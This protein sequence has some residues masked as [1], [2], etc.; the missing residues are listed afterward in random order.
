MLDFVKRDHPECNIFTLGVGLDYG[1]EISLWNRYPQCNMTAV[2]PVSTINKQ[3]VERI[4]NARF[5][6]ATIGDEDGIYMARLKK[7]REGIDA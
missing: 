4:P 1:G 7:Q 6:E 3:I 2:D 5:I